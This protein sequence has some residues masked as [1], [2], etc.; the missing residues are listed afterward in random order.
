MLLPQWMPTIGI[1]GGRINIVPVDFVVDALDHIAHTKGLDGKCFHLVDPASASHRRGAQHFRAGR[2]RAADD[3]AHQR[4]HVRLRPGADARRTWARSPPVKRMVRAVL[5]DLGIPEGRVQVHQLA[6]PLRLPRG[7]QGAQ[8]QRHRRAARC[9]AT[10]GSCG[11]TG[12]ATSTPTCSSTAASPA[13]RG[14]VV[15]VT[16]ASSGIGKARREK[17]AEAGARVILVARG[18]EKLVETKGGDRRPGRRGW[19][20]PADIS[21]LASC[22]ALVARVLAEHG[23]CDYLVNN[24]GR[25]IRRGVLNSYERFH[26]F[27]R[28]MQLNYFGALRLILGFLPSM[29][30]SGAATSSTS[31]P[32]A[33][34]PTPRASPPTWPRRPR[35]MP[36]T[37]ARPPNSS[38]RA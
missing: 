33:C 1:E 31:P 38:T 15:M 6:D 11:T 35:W 8:G 10:R 22:D 20:Y 21:D 26:D 9:K 24:A 3:H 23:G 17:I 32:S 37:A 5:N 30:S 12:S 14:K 2:A 18:E 36:S 25:S 34:S 19:I 29:S 16:G 13:R 28:T 4:A 7:D 27:E